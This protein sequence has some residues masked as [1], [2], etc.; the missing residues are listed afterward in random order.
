MGLKWI[1]MIASVILYCCIWI[2]MA[3]IF[4]DWYFSSEK[5]QLFRDLY[6]LLNNNTWIN[7]PFCLFIIYWW[8]LGIIRMLKDEDCRPYCVGGILLLLISINIKCNA[9]YP[10]I[11]GTFRFNVFFNILLLSYLAISLCRLFCYIWTKISK[12]FNI[13]EK[14]TN[15][16]FSVDDEYDEKLPANVKRYGE[17]LVEQ[18]LS[19]MKRSK[20]S[21]AVGITGEWGS[22]KTTFLNLL[23]KQL[24]K[25]AEIVEFNPW[26]CQTPEQVTR[27]FFA[28]LRNQL[29]QKHSSLSKPISYYAKCLEKVRISLF[30]NT[31]FEIANPA[32]GPSLLALKNELSLKF[33]TIDKPVVVFVDDLDR[34]ESKEVFEVLRLIRNTGDINNTIYITTFDK[35]YVTSV[36]KGIGCNA[37]ST[38]LEKIFPI[39]LHLP[40][41][42]GYQIWEVFKCELNAQ[43]TTGRRFAEKLVNS[44]SD[45]DYELILTILTNY[46]N[47]K[48]FCRLLMLNVNFVSKYYL[49]DFKYLDLFWI[50][51]LQFYDNQTYDGLARDAFIFLYYDSS[52]KRYILREG[53]VTAITSK[54]K[55]HHYLA[56]KTWRQQTPYILQRLFGEYIKTSSQ[57]IC[58]PENYMKFFAL[59][60][61]AQRLSINEFKHLTNG[62]QGYVQVIDDWIKQGK[63]ISSIE[64]NMTQTKTH[65]LSE[66]ELQNYLNGALYYGLKKQTWRNRSLSFLKTILTKGNFK[67]EKSAHDVVKRWI[68]E[69]IQH[70]DNLLSLSGILKFLYATKEY[71]SENPNEFTIRPTLLSNNEIEEM[72]ACIT[73]TYIEKNTSNINPLDI[74]KEESELFK[75][76]NNCCVESEST[77]I[78]GYSQYIQTSFDVI[79]E[80]FKKSKSK[81]TIELYNSCMS[82]LF[83]EQEPDPNSF[84]DP[85]DY[86][87]WQ[88]YESERYD[89]LMSSHFGSKY[90]K[91][92]E[93]FKLNCFQSI[94]SSSTEVKEKSQKMV[95][96]HKRTTV[97]KSRK[98]RRKGKGK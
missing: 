20:Q 15:N 21:I 5:T 6:V 59:G 31:W 82:E 65:T 75:L 29:S 51:L 83:H 4:Y 79:I 93:D 17:T 1:K 24:N 78:E 14:S 18:L 49:S 61:S 70:S 12:K 60:L 35:E 44:F 97:T 63:Y 48:R 84:L 40:K 26:M 85:N 67:D 46:R 38:Y 45:S 50:E 27:D 89:F 68:Q 64:Y 30:G 74:L 11:V 34:L 88:E 28:S 55:S 94:S 72:L 57:S 32:K 92:L 10:C 76:F 25:R 8:V 87:Q 98:K 39:E 52:S 47:V 9:I 91:N 54:D 58:H 69:Q 13:K 19:T 3:P 41:P 53:I 73:K 66:S 96:Q 37:P 71:D 81:P 56:E 62:K 86:Y 90:K 16:G 33:V 77:P 36:L 95:T 23:K 42:E 7:I 2:G 80:F 22:G 43:D